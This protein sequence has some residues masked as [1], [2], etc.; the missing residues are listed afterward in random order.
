M[1]ETARHAWSHSGVFKMTEF[2]RAF[3]ICVLHA[4]KELVRVV[5]I[6]H[7]RPHVKENMCSH[8]GNHGLVFCW[9]TIR[10]LPTRARMRLFFIFISRP[11][12][13]LILSKG[14]AVLPVTLITASIGALLSKTRSHFNNVLLFLLSDACGASHR[15]NDQRSVGWV[16]HLYY[17]YHILEFA[18]IFHWQLQCLS[19]RCFNLRSIF[20]HQKH[21]T[22]KKRKKRKEKSK[23]ECHTKMCCKKRYFIFMNLHFSRKL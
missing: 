19:Q 8:P 14:Q 11:I 21:I 23:E 17:R 6:G 1:N 3:Q 4:V 9:R 5:K 2:A 13:I 12:V 20:H 16:H 15:T 22:L 7:E 18:N 10:R